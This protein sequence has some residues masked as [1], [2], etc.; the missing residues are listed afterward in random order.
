MPGQPWQ[1]I[2]GIGNR[3]RHAYDRIGSAVIWNVVEGRLTALEADVIPAWADLS[4]AG[5][6]QARRQQR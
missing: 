2:R 4:A 6:S 3:L 5:A 1:D